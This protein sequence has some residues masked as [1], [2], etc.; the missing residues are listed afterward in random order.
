MDTKTYVFWCIIIMITAIAMGIMTWDF[1]MAH[2]YEGNGQIVTT[3][4]GIAF[5]AGTALYVVP[6]LVA[7]GIAKV[8]VRILDKIDSKRNKNEENEEDKN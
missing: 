8:S 6:G 2:I 7:F 1:V 3:R 5:C 4:V